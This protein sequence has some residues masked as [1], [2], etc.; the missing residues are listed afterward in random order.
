MT[1]GFLLS[2]SIRVHPWLDHFGCG[3]A[4]LRRIPSLLWLSCLQFLGSQIRPD[5]YDSRLLLF[6]ELPPEL[7][8]PITG[9]E[10]KAGAHGPWPA[11]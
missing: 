8:T 5:R 10:P 11:A 2:V 4:A 6:G 9:H 3:T 1:T 7:L